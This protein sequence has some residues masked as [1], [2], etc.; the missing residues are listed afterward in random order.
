[1][2]VDIKNIKKRLASLLE[3]TLANGAT[4][5]EVSAAMAAAMK[6]QAKYFPVDFK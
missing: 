6:I 5:A 4:E 1:M 2:A 3:K